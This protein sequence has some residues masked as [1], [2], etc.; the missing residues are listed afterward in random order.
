MLVNIKKFTAVTSALCFVLCVFAAFVPQWVFLDPNT[1]FGLRQMCS[2]GSCKPLYY[3]TVAA[4]GVD[5]VGGN[6][7]TIIDRMRTVEAFIWTG[8][9]FALASAFVAVV[10]LSGTLR[11][12]SWAATLHFTNSIAL[13]AFVITLAVGFA[14]FDLTGLLTDCAAGATCVYYGPSAVAAFIA[15]FTTFIALV[16]GIVA[17]CIAGETRGS[18]LGASL[19]LSVISAAFAFGAALSASWMEVVKNTTGLRPVNNTTGEQHNWHVNNTTGTTA[20]SWSSSITSYG[21]VQSCQGKTCTTGF[22]SGSNGSSQ[23]AALAMF[24][25]AFVVA[26]ATTIIAT[27][28]RL[29]PVRFILCFLQLACT[30]SGLAVAGS[31]YDR[32]LYNGETF[33]GYWAN[34]TS[35]QSGSWGFAF[36]SAVTSAMLMGITLLVHVVDSMWASAINTVVTEPSK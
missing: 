25:V 7:Y 9:A 15:L 24:I 10:G 5:K 21:L 2:G 8:A 35:P 20:L 27:A 14:T 11:V 32:N 29:R 31:L 12:V 36:A 23:K 4:L 1:T 3:A 17:Q 22:Q 33:A 28:T 18:V 30:I 19:G 6:T 34:Q 13:A 16:L 26:F